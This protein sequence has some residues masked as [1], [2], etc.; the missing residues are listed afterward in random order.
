MRQIPI[1]ELSA[2]HYWTIDRKKKRKKE[3]KNDWKSII[4]GG[5]FVSEFNSP[6]MYVCTIHTL[7]GWLFRRTWSRLYC[8]A[9]ILH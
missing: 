5:G 6:L 7:L 1:S 8:S 9:A 2:A 3:R 4:K